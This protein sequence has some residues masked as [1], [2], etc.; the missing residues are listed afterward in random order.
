MHSVGPL[1]PDGNG[2]AAP[3][4]SSGIFERLGRGEDL[5]DSYPQRR[6]LPLVLLGARLCA[7]EGR[8][9]D[10]GLGSAYCYTPRF[11]E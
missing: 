3:A 2:L 4:L 1:D 7:G 6:S 10:S 9:G 11:G 8:C 5:L